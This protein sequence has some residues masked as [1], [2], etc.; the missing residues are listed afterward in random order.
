[1]AGMS[2]RFLFSERPGKDNTNDTRTEQDRR[3]DDL[4]EGRVGQGAGWSEERRGTEALQA[5][6]KAHTAKN[7]AETNKELDAATAKLS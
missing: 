1:M 6:E 3:K 7:E 5:A 2:S 4:R